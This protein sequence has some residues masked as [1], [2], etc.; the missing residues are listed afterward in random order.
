MPQ[1]GDEVRDHLPVERERA[2]E[3][4]AFGAIPARTCRSGRSAGAPGCL[5]FDIGTNVPLRRA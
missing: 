3:Q 4:S 2:G 1:L 5:S